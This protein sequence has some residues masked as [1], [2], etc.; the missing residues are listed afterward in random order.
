M[1]DGA[2]SGAR[3]AGAGCRRVANHLAVRNGDGLIAG[4][5]E[6]DMKQSIEK[7]P[8]DGVAVTY[9]VRRCIHA[10]AC[11]RGLPSV[12]NRGRRPW[13]DPSRSSP[14]EITAVV[15]RCP[16]GALKA[17]RTDGSLDETAPDAV[18][19]RVEADGPLYVHGRVELVDRAGSPVL[20]D[21]R[22]ALCRCGLSG[23]KP[24][25]D[26]THAGRFSD[27]GAIG[28]VPGGST[29]DPPSAAVRVRANSNGSLRIEGVVEVTSHDGT[30]RVR[31]ANAALCRCGASNKKPFC[32]GTHRQI[33]FTTD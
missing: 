32:D 10:E 6:R 28:E 26:N 30:R 9:D 17:V 1:V 11:V 31:K 27:A 25:C 20:R 12:F 23:N 4:G 24:L 18:R 2:P 14:D 33:G 7:Y 16:T 19:I 5:P 3:A 8:G 15:G 13:I 22:I 29:N 21:V